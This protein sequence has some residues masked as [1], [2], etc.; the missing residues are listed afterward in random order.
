VTDFITHAIWVNPGIDYYLVMADQTKKGLLSWGVPGE[1]IKVQGIPVSSKFGPSGQQGL[2]RKKHGV[3]AEMFTVLIMGGGF[4]IGRIHK[5]VDTFNRYFFDSVQLVVVC[6]KNHE[7]EKALRASSYR[8][9]IKCFG[10]VDIIDELM[11][12]S[13]IVI[14]KGGA[15]TICESLAKGRPIIIF[16]PIPGQ[17]AYNTSFLLDR[18]AALYLKRTGQIK[19]IMENIFNHPNLLSGLKENG[20]LINKATAASEIADFMLAFSRQ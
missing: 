9:R 19:E 2:Y 1:R 6:G 8:I 11:E 5:L 10:Y 12:A 18:K 4:G 20:A 7:L 15:L 13:D 16:D 3:N 14:T 17:E